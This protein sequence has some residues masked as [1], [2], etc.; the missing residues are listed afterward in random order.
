MAGGCPVGR[1][2]CVVQHSVVQ[3]GVVVYRGDRPTRPKDRRR[4]Q[5]RRPLRPFRVRPG[6]RPPGRRDVGRVDRRPDATCGRG[7]APGRP[8][9]RGVHRCGARPAG[10]LH[11]HRHR[12]AVLRRHARGQD[13]DARARPRA[14]GARA[15]RP[16]RREHGGGARDHEGDRAGGRPRDPR[17]RPAE[18][19]RRPARARGHPHV[20]GDRRPRDPRRDRDRLAREPRPARPLDPGVPEGPEAVLPVQGHLVRAVQERHV[21]LHDHPGGVHGALVLLR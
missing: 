13:D 18:L 4:R 8:L 16:G 11:L 15:R 3:R 1:F 7:L 10:I 21:R 19:P 5:G 9:H 6:P 14:R 12:A 20:P 17:L 2:V